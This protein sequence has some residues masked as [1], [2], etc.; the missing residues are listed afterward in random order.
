MT[1]QAS[2]QLSILTVSD[3]PVPDLPME[4]RELL[5]LIYLLRQKTSFGRFLALKEASAHS[6]HHTDHNHVKIPMTKEHFF[7]K[8]IWFW[9]VMLCAFTWSKHADY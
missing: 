6:E 3:L 1:K 2:L 4:H 9:G 5:E 8:K 7:K